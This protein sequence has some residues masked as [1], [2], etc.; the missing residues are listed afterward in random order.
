MDRVEDVVFTAE[1]VVP[2][3]RDA[4]FSFF[5]DPF[6]L[7]AITP[8]W[9]RFRVV[10]R[11]TDEIREGTELTY[12]LR[13]RGLPMTWR[14]RIEEWRANER[15]VDVQL[16]G[17]YAKWRHTHTFADHGD[18]ETLISDRV[19]YRLPL[20][21]LGGLVAGRLVAA[22]VRKIF[23]YR[24]ERTAELIARGSSR[25]RRPGTV[26]GSRNNK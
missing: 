3:P 8:P 18:G 4:V 1:Q 24:A 15:F 2:A 7:E 9:L 12:R 19:E 6:N 14:S 13:L 10:E 25:R 26:S 23:R 11:T 17:P 22:D 20:G 16:R 5:S 21:R